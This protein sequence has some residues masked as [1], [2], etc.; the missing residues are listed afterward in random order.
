MSQQHS[1]NRFYYLDGNINRMKE[2]VVFSVGVVLVVNDFVTNNFLN[3]CIVVVIFF[4]VVVFEVVIE[5]SR[6]VVV[7]SDVIDE[8]R[9]VEVVKFV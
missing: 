2:A 9:I 6:V 3:H 5:I 7:S 4:F 8:V 1:V